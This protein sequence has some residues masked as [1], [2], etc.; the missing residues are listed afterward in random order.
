MGLVKAVASVVDAIIN[1]D[2]NLCPS[3]SKLQPEPMGREIL[4]LTTGRVM[5]CAANPEHPPSHRPYHGC[6][7]PYLV[8]SLAGRRKVTPAWSWLGKLGSTPSIY[9]SIRPEAERLLL[10]ER[11]RAR[12]RR[13]EWK[14]SQIYR[15][16]QL[17]RLQCQVIIKVCIGNS[18]CP[19]TGKPQPMFL[20]RCATCFGELNE[21]HDAT[22]AKEI[23]KREAIELAAV[24]KEALT[25]V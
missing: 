1:P 24:R 19:G 10:E 18:S 13:L 7:T 2:D 17:E 4:K 20:Q 12:A 9:E 3:C 23:E 21:S 11:E 6:G 22:I 8:F 5:L 14:E 25:W 15:R 16:F